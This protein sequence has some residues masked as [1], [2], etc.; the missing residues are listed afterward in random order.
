MPAAQV[1]QQLPGLQRHF[2]E[3]LDSLAGEFFS[4]LQNSVQIVFS[5][6]HKWKL[7]TTIAA[8]LRT[9][10][11][12]LNKSKSFFLS[13][14]FCFFFLK[15]F[16]ALV[17]VVSKICKRWPKMAEQI[18]SLRIEQLTVL[19]Q[20]KA[21]LTFRQRIHLDQLIFTFNGEKTFIFAECTSKDWLAVP[22]QFFSIKHYLGFLGR[23]LRPSYHLS[24]WKFDHEDMPGSFSS[25]ERFLSAFLQKKIMLAKT[26][27]P[28]FARV[29]FFENSKTFAINIIFILITW[30]GTRWVLCFVPNLSSL[31]FNQKVQKANP[32]F[33]WKR[34]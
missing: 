17:A 18:W 15:K 25:S 13:F 33:F 20:C 4:K 14:V 27:K 11:F 32:N 30:Q 26:V 9:E 24:T 3:I 29:F 34:K 28:C 12:E 10:Y 16:I 5:K 31:P 8:A 21:L 22:L 7:T 2:V 19:L 23:H 6:V 1:R